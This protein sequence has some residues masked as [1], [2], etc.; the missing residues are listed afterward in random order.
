MGGGDVARGGLGQIYERENQALRDA[1]AEA[2][3]ECNRLRARLDSLQAAHD[4]LNVAQR[5]AAADAEA[6][7]SELRT[8]VRRRPGG[9]CRCD[10]A[11]HGL[12]TSV[13]LLAY[14]SPH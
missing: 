6:A 10:G 13:L 2:V 14:R 12:H 11:V 3:A 1:R 8:Q 5:S 9:L 4:S 7:M